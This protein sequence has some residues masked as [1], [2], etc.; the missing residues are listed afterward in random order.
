MA[1][2]GDQNDGFFRLA[3]DFP[4][5]RDP[6]SP[7]VEL[8]DVSINM[9]DMRISNVNVRIDMG[10]QVAILGPHGAAAKSTLLNLLA[11]DL[12]PTEGEVRRSHNLRIGR[13]SQHMVDQLPMMESPL[14]YLLPLYP[15]HQDQRRW[16]KEDAVGLKLMRFGLPK[17]YHQAPFS[18]LSAGQKASVVLASISMSNP[19][20]L[21]LDEPTNHL[22]ETTID[23]LARSLARFAGGLVLVSHDARLLSR[24]CR[25]EDKSE[26]WVVEDG[27]FTFFRGTFKDYNSQAHRV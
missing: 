26:I 11:G 5:P 14:K 13:Y 2:I 1:A 21:L 23:A 18:I 20:I 15:P 16:F 3:L 6:P 10:T 27:T 8:I 12:V 4:E 19:H 17:F 25:R 24:V 22:D 7:L 9:P